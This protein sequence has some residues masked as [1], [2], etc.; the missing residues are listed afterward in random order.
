MHAAPGKRALGYLENGFGIDFGDGA[1]PH[2]A[3]VTSYFS[4]QTELATGVP[5]Q[6][7]EKEYEAYSSLK[8]IR[9]R[10]PSFDVGQFMLDHRLSFGLR[11]PAH[12]VGGEQYCRTKQSAQGWR[13]NLRRQQES[14]A[15]RSDIQI[16]RR[17]IRCVLEDPLYLRLNLEQTDEI[18]Q[19]TRQPDRKE[20]WVDDTRYASSFDVRRR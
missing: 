5:H 20:R 10:V 2:H 18:D 4:F 16:D 3:V 9:Q 11:R 13:L 1:A 12:D 17:Y 14:Y 7:M 8:E 15:D 19:Q 6:R